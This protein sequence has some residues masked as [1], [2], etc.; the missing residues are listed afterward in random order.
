MKVKT[1]SYAKVFPIAAYVNEKIGVEVELDETDGYEETFLQA[2][3]LVEK[4]HKDN[5]PQPDTQGS[6]GRGGFGNALDLPMFQQPI[7]SVDISKEREW[8]G[9]E[10]ILEGINKSETINLLKT[11]QLLAKKFPETE[12]AYENKLQSLNV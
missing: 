10:Y 4:F 9:K 7:Q 8:D 2:K 11:W 12:Q 1:I 3:Q 6:E 5:N